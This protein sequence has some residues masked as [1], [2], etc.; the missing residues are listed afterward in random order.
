MKK[1]VLLLTGILTI[2]SA[3]LLNA[4]VNVGS[5]AAPDLS[6]AL[7]LSTPDKGL[8]LPQISLTSTSAYLTSGTSSSATIGMEVYNTNTGITGSLAYP[9]SGEGIYVWDGTGWKSAIPPISNT[10][11]YS[12]GGSQSTAANNVFTSNLDLGTVYSIVPQY[13]AATSSSITIKVAGTYQIQWQGSFTY[14]T[15]EGSSNNTG[16]GNFKFSLFKNGTELLRP[17]IAKTYLASGNTG[18]GIVSPSGLVTY[19]FALAA[20]DVI[21][22]QARD[23]ASPNGQG[24]NLD[25][26]TISKL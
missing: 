8:R 11:Y 9:A 20:G 3:T 17:L 7:Q 15:Q 5:T 25:I 13:V 19:T 23:Y 22:F 24:F 16:G 14:N 2:G 1:S 6:A 26:V 18:T 12:Y 21:S 10:V 4:Q